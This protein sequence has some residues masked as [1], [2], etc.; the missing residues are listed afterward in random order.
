MRRLLI[1]AVFTAALQGVAGAEKQ[2]YPSQPIVMIV[3]LAP[4]GST[5]VIAR[6]LAERLR[7]VLG[8]PVI[9]ENVSGAGGTIGVGRLARAAPDG[10]TIGVGQWGTNVITGAIYP[11]PFDLLKD[12]E[13]IALIATQPFL[14]IARKTMPATNL[15]GLINWLKA[16]ANTASQGNAG[17]GSP[18]HAADCCA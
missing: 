16:N 9:I 2:P 11:L 14:I 3:P 10:Y 7:T 12:F 17:V 1:V 15:P 6:I 18:S 4:G 13:P 5:D 8:Q